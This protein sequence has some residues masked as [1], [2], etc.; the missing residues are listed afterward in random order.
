MRCLLVYYT[1]T[2][3]TRYVT[4]MLKG[5]LEEK[6]VEVETYEIDFLNLEKLDLSSYDLIGLGYPIYGFNAPY[7]FLKF[8]RKQKFP[9]GIKCFIY[10]N[11][12]E[13]Y[14]ANDA[15]SLSVRNKIRRDKAEITNEYHFMM[16][17]NIHF[18]FEDNLI[19][20]MLDM[21]NKLMDILIKE[22][23]D[24]IPNIKKY[25]FIH[26]MIT[27]IVRIQFIGG[28]INSF[29]YK[30]DNDKCSRCGLCVKK[31]PTKN[32]YLNKKNKI[33]FH[34]KC[35]MCMRCSFMCPKDAIK[36]GLFESW[37]VNGP[38]DFKK[39]NAL[40][41]DKPVIT[42]ETKGFFKCY[43]ENYEYIES[44]YKELLVE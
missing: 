29:F 21:D 42:K 43:I 4:T 33:K 39:I 23:L 8:I 20:E 7:A 30:V 27:R 1:G 9:K 14:H 26:K 12:G 41:N 32:I 16:P 11:S 18:R 35:L 44:R 17:Y 40:N 28:N 22:V 19:K 15:S 2:Y 6:N 31:C 36:I 37:H 13:T 10:K 5:K 24:D 38:Y 25:K 3:N 34:H